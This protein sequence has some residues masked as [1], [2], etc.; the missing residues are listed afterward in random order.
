MTNHVIITK[1]PKSVGVSII[2]AI[3][4]GPL[5]LFYASVFGGIVMTLLPILI[6]C[7]LLYNTLLV[8]E[9]SIFHLFGTLV[10]YWIFILIH[11][12]STVAWA[13][14]AT[15]EYNSELEAEYKTQLD[16]GRNDFY[17]D[18]NS[19]FSEWLKSNPGKSLNDY[20]TFINRKP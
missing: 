17:L 2:L 12:V 16:Y 10:T 1:S 15:L 3:A 7:V 4:L 13:V 14:W 20:Y 6:G 8:G 18:R 5:G 19:N 11:W 9:F